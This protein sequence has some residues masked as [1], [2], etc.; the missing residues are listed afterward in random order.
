MGWH[1]ADMAQQFVG[2][3]VTCL[4]R[5]AS[6]SRDSPEA[7][8]HA[9]RIATV[10][11]WGVIWREGQ[12]Q[13]EQRCRRQLKIRALAFDAQRSEHVAVAECEAG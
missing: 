9:E 7:P 11:D 12:R 4:P 8:E 1:V 6:W 13:L 2:M 5:Q 10:H 3:G